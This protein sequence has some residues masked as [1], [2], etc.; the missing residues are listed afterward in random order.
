MGELAALEHVSSSISTQFTFPRLRK[1]APALTS[2]W[3]HPCCGYT[4]TLVFPFACSSIAFLTYAV[5]PTFLP[6]SETVVNGGL[7]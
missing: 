7:T 4:S 1:S 3:T 6:A 5:I 2:M